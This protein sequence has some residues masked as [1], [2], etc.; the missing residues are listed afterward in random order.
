[1]PYRRTYGMQK[2]V[3]LFT[4]TTAIVIASWWW[5][6]A[7]VPMPPSPLDPGEKLY[8]VSYAPFRGAQSPLDLS[9]RIEA[10]QID[11]D[12]AQL[13]TMT[14]CVRTYSVDFG[15]DQVPEIAQRHG[16]KVLLGLWVSSHTDR[17]Q[18]QISTGVALAN[19]FPDVVRAII[20]GN[21]A[22]LRGEVSPAMLAEIIGTVKSRVK[23]P[24]TYA[25]VWEFWLRYSEL[26]TAVDFITIHILPYWEDDPVAARNAADHVDAIRKR[27]A[28]YFPGK[29]VV[30]GEVGW[31]SAGRMREGALPSPANLARVMADVLERG[32]REHFRVNVIEAFDQPWKRALEGTVGGHWGLFDDATHRQKFAWG[33]PVSNHPHWPWQ[34]AAGVV[35][36]ALIF[37]AGCWGRRRNGPYEI[38]PAAWWAI[39]ANATVA[40]VLAGWTVENVP[41][42]SLGI[43][44][45]LRGLSFAALSVAV[46]VISAA[47]MA[48]QVAPPSFAKIVGPKLERAADP[49]TLMFGILLLALTV[50]TVQSALSLA[51][52]PRYRDFPFAPLTAA[53]LP[54]LLGRV[55]VPPAAGQR[56]LAETMAGAVMAPCAIF[57]VWN[58]TLANW[59]AVWFAAAVVAL[60]LSLIRARVAPG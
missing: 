17:T 11:R 54:F 33:M 2:P 28:D 18:Y 34:A 5:L 12:L 30:I 59:Q 13:A 15:L 21:E 22:L 8:C 37:A 49:L 41:I 23:A 38:G 27:V 42:E 39:A 31:P 1:M 26:A 46:P 44:G 58:E 50:L 9:T 19:R 60:T 10:A 57:I 55:L 43:G 24:V 52:D 20:V 3:S 56:A 40:G 32:R 35:L 53:A 48:R 4:L 51:F 29:E 6:G 36:A 47:A 7:A 14:D 45:W 25:D 16:L